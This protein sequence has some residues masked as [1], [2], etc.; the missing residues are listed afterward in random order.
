MSIH[1]IWAQNDRGVIGKDGALP[2]HIPEDLARFRQITRGKPVIMGRATWD[3]LPERFRPLP[4]R[5][6][7]VLT[8]N[9]AWSQE[10]AETATSVDAVLELVGDVETWVIGG[11]GV[12]EQ[13]L[14]L[15]Q[16]CE[17]TRVNLP[18]LEGDAFIATLGPQWERVGQDPELG[19]HVSHSSIQY[20]FES[21]ARIGVNER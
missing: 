14:P 6:N 11:S 7:I 9:T 18:E 2:W 5:R 15:A 17:V 12:Y 1:L 20:R 4:G 21:Y 19:W 3:S 8:R 10:G 16:T 13:F